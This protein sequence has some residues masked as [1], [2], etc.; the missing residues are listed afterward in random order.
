MVPLISIGANLGASDDNL[1][2]NIVNYFSA[3]QSMEER[4]GLL[5]RFTPMIPKVCVG[6]G[7]CA[8]GVCIKICRLLM[9]HCRG[10]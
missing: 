3:H 10:V 9:T 1:E 5:W 4:G 7:V 6:M 2:I 8:E